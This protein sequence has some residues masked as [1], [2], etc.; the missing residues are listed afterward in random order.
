MY[1]QEPEQE[2]DFRVPADVVELVFAIDCRAL[3]VD[4]ADALH[5]ALIAA[6]PWLA[7]AAGLG[8]HAIHGAGSQNGWQRPPHGTDSWLQLPRRTKLRLRVPRPL[9][10][11]LLTTL[12]GTHLEVAGQALNI[13]QGHSRALD[14]SPTQFARHIVCDA[15]EDENTFLD[16][17]AATLARV[18]VRMRKALCGRALGLAT[19]QGP[20]H[21]RSL[22]LANL[23][24][25]ESIRLQQHGLGPHRHLGCGLFIAHKGIDPVRPG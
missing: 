9:A 18:E 17:A 1:W 7:E 12:P 2:D 5:R 6:Q 25:D 24:A 20:L 4:H 3:P 16:R 21:T 10:E 13:G 8:I 19:A 23:P 11:A 14:P 15:D 22:L